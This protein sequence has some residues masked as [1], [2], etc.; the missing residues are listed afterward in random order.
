MK[1]SKNLGSMQG[2]GTYETI[3]KEG[4]KCITLS[5]FNIWL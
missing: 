4:Y 5:N 3:V 1:E 2:S